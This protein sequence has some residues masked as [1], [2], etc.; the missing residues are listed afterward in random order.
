MRTIDWEEIIKGPDT[1]A[2]SPLGEWWFDQVRGRQ[3][4]Q[5][6]AASSFATKCNIC[7]FEFESLG[8][9]SAPYLSQ[10]KMVYDMYIHFSKY[11]EEF[12]ALWEWGEG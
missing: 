2:S 3:F 12:L 5:N 8:S 11:P 6:D 4:S 9:E 1:I 7:G 10:W